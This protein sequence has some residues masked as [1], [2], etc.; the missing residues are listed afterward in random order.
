MALNKLSGTVPAE[1]EA[2]GGGGGGVPECSFATA[3]VRETRMASGKKQEFLR[4]M[5]KRSP[6]RG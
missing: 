3:K 5:E 4:I 2:S 1:A 6:Q